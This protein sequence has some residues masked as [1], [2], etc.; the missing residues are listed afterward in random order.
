MKKVVSVLL[1]VFVIISCNKKTNVPMSFDYGSIEN[2]IY[3][4]TFFKF[5]LPI[6]SEWYVLDN[7]EADAVY[8]IGN[9]F[10]SG[11]NKSLKKK[12]SASQINVAKLLTVFREEPGTNITYNPSIIVNAENL[13]NSPQVK[14]VNDYLSIAKKLLN[15]TAMDI[16]YLEQ[17]DLV[18]IGS[19]DFGFLKIENK[20]NGTNIIQDYYVALKKGFAVSFIMS[21]TNEEEKDMLYEMFNKL[22]I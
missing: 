13:N 4:N 21:Y 15:N 16:E 22:K 6:N 5:K 19:Q 11:D 12:L 10:A 8:K 2:G 3:D 7:E 14:S 18:K 17:K 9:E 20:F 1:I